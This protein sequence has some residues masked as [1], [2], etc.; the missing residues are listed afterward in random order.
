MSR[1]QVMRG[2]STPSQLKRLSTTM[3]LGMPGALSR[4]SKD[5][6]ARR[7]PTR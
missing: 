4:S 1:G 2:L 5:R 7:L 6:S 3:P